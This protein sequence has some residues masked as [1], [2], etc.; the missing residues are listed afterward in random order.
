MLRGSS[1]DSRRSLPSQQSN[2]FT[3]DGRQIQVPLLVATDVA[4]TGMW[5]SDAG[6][7]YT[8]FAE[9]T[10]MR[11]QGSRNQT[12]RGDM[13]EIP[14]PS[15]GED[16]AAF[17]AARNMPTYQAP[18]ALS[19]EFSTSAPTQGTF[20]D[21]YD[22]STT[23]AAY[24]TRPLTPSAMAISNEYSQEM[25]RQNSS[26]TQAA[27]N[28]VAMMAIKSTRS[29]FSTESRDGSVDAISPI[30]LDHRRNGSYTMEATSTPQQL[31]T[32]QP[33]SVAMDRS[34]SGSSASSTRSREQLQRVNQFAAIRPIKPKASESIE[35]TVES[36]DDKKDLAKHVAIVKSSGYVRPKREPLK[37]E[38]CNE[39][40]EGYRGPHEL[41]RHKQRAHTTIV[42]R[43]KSAEPSGNLPDDAPKLLKALSDCKQCSEGKS[44]GIDYNAAAHLRRAHFNPK[45]KTKGKSHKSEKE[46][47]AAKS[48]GDWPKME[49]LRPWLVE[50]SCE[51]SLISGHDEE[52]YDNDFDFENLNSM[53]EEEYANTTDI[54][55]VDNGNFHSINDT[56]PYSTP[57]TTRDF[58]ASMITTPCGE[59]GAANYHT[60][61]GQAM[62]RTDSGYATQIRPQEIGHEQCHN[63][64]INPLTLPLQLSHQFYTDAT[65]MG[66]FDSAALVNTTSFADLSHFQHSTNL[67]ME[68][69]PA[70]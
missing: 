39:K 24:T 62:Q 9:H 30:H 38:L 17:F 36:K 66:L 69:Y 53:M 41:N 20:A 44:Y 32:Q 49:Q 60:P 56:D 27:L 10:R 55:P 48:G 18:V 26:F 11:R 43:W 2:P 13:S 67:Y 29:N 47:R 34:D 33:A 15:V 54:V 70:C 61:S 21:H 42:K 46:K 40:P 52:D 59:E 51:N 63:E 16:P 25:S 12:E 68:A 4:A 31:F 28:G 57:V 23:L 1:N 6:N 64:L 37:C 45:S 65:T 3:G 5:H 8:A 19:H 7:A 58:P 22:L 14:A 35:K 50:T